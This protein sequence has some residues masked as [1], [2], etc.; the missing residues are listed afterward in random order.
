MTGKSIQHGSKDSRKKQK[1][2]GCFGKMVFFLLFMTVAV[3]AVLKV[4]GILGG[5]SV[6]VPTDNIKVDFSV[7][8]EVLSNQIDARG[9]D[10]TASD[11]DIEFLKK[12]AAKQTRYSQEINFFIEHISAY[13]QMAVNTVILSPEKISFVLLEPFAEIQG[14]D[15]GVKVRKGTVPYFIQ[16][17]SRWGF[18]EYGGGV[19]GYTACGPTCLAMAAA[20]IT[21]D[22]SYTP[23]YMSEYA[24]QNGYYVSGTGTAWSL[25]T[26][27][28][29]EFGLAGQE[30]SVDEYDMF[31]RLRRGEVIIASMSYGDFT[32]SGH[33]IVIYGY[34]LGSFKIYDPSSIERSER[35]WSIE[36]LNGQIAQLWSISAA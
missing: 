26:N 30:I 8:F 15:S 13:S 20:G 33:F 29:S 4:S 7:D 27:G 6:K 2:R 11:S 35:T 10:F 36:Q 21:G 16:Y 9:G 12:I 34:A 22:E 18:A 19:I 32:Y 1:K 31:K 25:F 5:S 28:V 3:I 23:L 14:Y 24:E 17:D